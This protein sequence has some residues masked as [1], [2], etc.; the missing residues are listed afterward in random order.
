ME[1][2]LPLTFWGQAGKS[3]NRVAYSICLMFLKF[4]IIFKNC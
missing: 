3:A 1:T 2:E 4:S